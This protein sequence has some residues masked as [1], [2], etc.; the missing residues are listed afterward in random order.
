MPYRTCSLPN[1]ARVSYLAVHPEEKG[2]RTH[3]FARAAW[4]LNAFS[5][6]ANVYTEAQRRAFGTTK[7]CAMRGGAHRN[8]NT[9]Y[10]HA[11]CARGALK[12]TTYGQNTTAV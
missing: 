12:R 4:A 6:L 10:A 8:A 9:S 2:R 11:L 1:N 5:S 7:R 3:T